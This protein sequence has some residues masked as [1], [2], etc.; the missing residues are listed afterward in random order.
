MANHAHNPRL[1]FSDDI[2][3]IDLEPVYPPQQFEPAWDRDYTG[4]DR[5]DPD[6]LNLARGLVWALIASGIFWAAFGLY[7]LV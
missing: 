7:L 3:P 5:E 4:Y 2:D 1:F 6:G